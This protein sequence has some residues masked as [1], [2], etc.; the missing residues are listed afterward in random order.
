[1]FY[2]KQGLPLITR[3]ITAADSNR[4]SS[5]RRRWNGIDTDTKTVTTLLD[6]LYRTAKITITV[7]FVVVVCIYANY[8]I[9][10]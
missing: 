6:G 10:I 7:V 8:D 9:T 5:G 4:S 2:A 1:M 3:C